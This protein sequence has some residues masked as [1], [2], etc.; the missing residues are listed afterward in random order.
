[1]NINDI[2]NALN[3]RK[4]QFVSA[5][6]TT[7]VTTKAEHK[8]LNVTKTTTATVRTGITYDNMG[9]VQD[10]RENGELPAENAGLPEWQKWVVFPYHLRH[11]TKGTDYVRLYTTEN[12]PT[13]TYR[14]DGREATKADVLALM[15]PSGA[16]AATE[17]KALDCFQVTAE[18][19]ERIG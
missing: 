5:T 13:V 11:T 3:G 19:V 4:G 9:A 12:V 18:N 16:K 8:A 6:W 1:M 14:I 7:K 2:L 17:R 10:K 15:T